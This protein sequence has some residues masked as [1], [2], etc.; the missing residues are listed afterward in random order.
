[1]V[2]EF[3]FNN[4]TSPTAN[5]CSYGYVVLVQIIC[6]LQCSKCSVDVVRQTIRSPTFAADFTR[7]KITSCLDLALLSRL[8][9]C[10]EQNALVLWS[11]FTLPDCVPFIAEISITT[12]LLS[13]LA[14][15]VQSPRSTPPPALSPSHRG[16]LPVLHLSSFHSSEG[17][18]LGPQS[19]RV[20]H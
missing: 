20:Y 5:K 17:A 11:W 3:D 12:S 4:I 2:A 14:V 15:G 8:E 18:K 7:K 16:R 10:S 13:P 6:T 1:M 9:M 19:L